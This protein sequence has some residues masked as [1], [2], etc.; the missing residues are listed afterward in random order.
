[1]VGIFDDSQLIRGKIN[2]WL[3][4]NL[5]S[6]EDGTIKSSLDTL[7]F[8]DEIGGIGYLAHINS[9]DML[10]KGHMSGG[11]KKKVLNQSKIM[12]ISDLELIHKTTQQIQSYS[13]NTVHF[14]LIRFSS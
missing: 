12:G 9:S 5:I 6:Q 13:K 8:I 1:M 14:F 10:Q 11:Y 7:D 2:S 3:E 4:D